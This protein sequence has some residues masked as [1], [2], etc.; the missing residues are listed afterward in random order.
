[1]YD[2]VVAIKCIEDITWLCM[3]GD[4]KF[5]SIVEKYFMSKHG[6]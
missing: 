1:M 6:E 2:V 3:H 5:L 4:T